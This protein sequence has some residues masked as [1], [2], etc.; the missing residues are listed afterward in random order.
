[1]SNSHF[2][3]FT[4]KTYLLL[5][6][7]VLTGCIYK[8]Q[9]ITGKVVDE[10][11]NSIPGVMVS[12]CYSGWGW[13]V[14]G[15]VW[16]KRYCSEPV[17]TD[18]DGVY[19]IGF[20]GPDVMGFKIDKEGWVQTKSHRINDSQIVLMRRDKYFKQLAIKR[21][22]A[23]EIFRVRQPN[24][25]NADYYCRVIL[26]DSGKIKLK[27]KGQ[28]LKIAQTLMSYPDQSLNI[29]S[30]QGDYKLANDFAS[31]VRLRVNREEVDS[32]IHVRKDNTDCPKDIFFLEVRLPYSTNEFSDAIEILVPS[33]KALF[34]MYIWND[35]R[36]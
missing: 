15:L 20:R 29:F 33:V 8:F 5:S 36:Q 14:N 34:D 9:S 21:K 6:L 23:E 2:Y 31:E 10:L 26:N 27:Y 32:D 3:I 17:I 4:K 22:L 19:S 11:G 28:R 13:S 7:I 35:V 1:M 25:S 30:V 24:E 16:D 18:V 12:A